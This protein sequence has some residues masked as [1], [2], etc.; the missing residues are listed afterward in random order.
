MVVLTV[1]QGIIKVLC[2]MN[3]I[4]WGFW[5]ELDELDPMRETITGTVDSIW[6]KVLSFTPG[7]VQ[8]VLGTTFGKLEE[9]W[10]MIPDGVK[11]TLPVTLMSCILS[12]ILIPYMIYKMDEYHEKKAERKGKEMKKE[13]GLEVIKK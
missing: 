8:T 11:E 1:A 13:K 5:M 12:C 7:V 9:V 2:A 3:D 4:A 6:N 10:E